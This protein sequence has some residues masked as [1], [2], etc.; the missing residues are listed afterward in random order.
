MPEGVSGASGLSAGVVWTGSFHRKGSIMPISLADADWTKAGWQ[1]RRPEVF[2]SIG[3]GEALE[4][5][6]KYYQLG[7]TKT[8]EKGEEDAAKPLAQ[9]ITIA[10]RKAGALVTK[11]KDAAEKK[12]ALDLIN[13]YETELEAFQKEVAD[14]NEVWEKQEE[15]KK[16][17]KAQTEKIQKEVDAITFDEIFSD[18]HM[19]K[20][21]TDFCHNEDVYLFNTVMKAKGNKGDRRDYDT[22]IRPGGSKE[23]NIDGYAKAKTEQIAMVQMAKDEDAGQ[24]VKWGD[25]DWKAFVTS[26]VG[27]LRKEASSLSSWKKKLLNERLE[28][29]VKE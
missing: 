25:A 5:F 19:F 18:R 13:A 11:I 2:K 7:A 8:F 22:F 6:K 1:K 23:I 16:R 29:E 14:L 9:K 26:S 20:T 10:L 3:M 17:I 21:Y 24:P 4:G 12:Q 27:H 15:K 28:K